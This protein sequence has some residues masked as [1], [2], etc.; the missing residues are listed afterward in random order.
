MILFSHKMLVNNK[1]A[2][3]GGSSSACSLVKAF[4]ACRVFF[5][6]TWTSIKIYVTRPTKINHMS[7]KNHWFLSPLLY[8]NLWT[9]NSN[10]IISLP[11]LQNLMDYDWASFCNL[12]KLDT[13][14]R[15]DDISKN[16][17]QCKLHSHGWSL[18]AQSYIWMWFIY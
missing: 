15:T 14:F 10:A 5:F 16:I 1:P 8:H 12:Q 3:V 2:W 7:T 18:Q 4:S 6:N 13:T 9:V 11:P 17:N